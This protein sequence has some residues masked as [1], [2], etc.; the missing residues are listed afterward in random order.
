MSRSTGVRTQTRLP[1]AA[2][3][4][5][6]AGAARAQRPGG[7]STS[8]D[9]AGRANGGATD[10][11][12]SWQEDTPPPTSP[13]RGSVAPRDGGG[14]GPFAHGLRGSGGAAAGG[15]GGGA[16]VGGREVANNI[17]SLQVRTTERLPSFGVAS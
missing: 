2:T 5:T 13:G 7:A 8:H 10:S 4:C 1:G 17:V 12:G 14:E 9:P 3:A 15:G 11:Q 16:L 6:V